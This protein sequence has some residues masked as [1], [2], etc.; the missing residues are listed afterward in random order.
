MVKR[1]NLK[2]ERA[3]IQKALNA[4]VRKPG[5]DIFDVCGKLEDLCMQSL[6]IGQPN[7]SENEK[8]KTSADF[9]D[10]L[11]NSLMMSVGGIIIDGWTRL[12]EK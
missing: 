5:M 10:T 8:R 12:Q 3:K 7:T 4:I 9:V 1:I 2:H 6:G 11:D